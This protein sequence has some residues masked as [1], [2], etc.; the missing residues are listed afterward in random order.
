MSFFNKIVKFFVKEEPEW[1]DDRFVV[2]YAYDHKTR[3][4]NARYKDEDDKYIGVV[5]YGYDKSKALLDLQYQNYG[6]I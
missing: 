3:L 2:V 5:G 4:W 1:S 6:I